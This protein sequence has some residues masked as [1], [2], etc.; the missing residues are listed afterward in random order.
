MLQNGRHIRTHILSMAARKLHRS[1]R[2]E[3]SCRGVVLLSFLH[4]KHVVTLGKACV[5]TLLLTMLLF[6]HLAVGDDRDVVQGRNVTALFCNDQYFDENC[7]QRRV[8]IFDLTHRSL[9]VQTYSPVTKKY[10]ADDF[11]LVRF[12]RLSKRSDLLGE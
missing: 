7:G 2:N 12:S 6:Y 3:E 1:K 5:I 4:G 11:L 9:E 10:Y 8:L